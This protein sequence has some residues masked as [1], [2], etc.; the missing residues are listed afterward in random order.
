MCF[1]SQQSQ[2][3]QKLE[4]RHKAKFVDKSSYVKGVY[5]GFAH[6]KTPVITNLNLEEIHL[7]H[8]GLIPSWAADES[9]AKN[10]LN[11]R[12]ETIREKPSFKN[13]IPNR[14][15][16]LID[17]FYEWEWLDAK[18]K[19]KQK[20]LITMPQNEPYALAGIW[21][22]WTNKQTGEI[23]PTYTIL[24][25]EANELMSKIHNTKKRMPLVVANEKEWLAGE[26]AILNNDQFVANKIF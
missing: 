25:M 8:W 20:Y 1:H 26:K 13:Y 18:G 5:S 16:I 7:Y 17:G 6:P 12:V 24:T 22:E 4:S 2:D 15:L 3:A 11:A 9:I 19:E 23:K 10:T 14:C 21:S